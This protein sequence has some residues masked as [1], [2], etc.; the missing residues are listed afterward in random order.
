VASAENSVTSHH[1]HTPDTSRLH[2]FKNFGHTGVEKACEATVAMS[3]VLD[4]IEMCCWEIGEES[5]GMVGQF[6]ANLL[7]NVT[8]CHV[9]R[10]CGLVLKHRKFH[11]VC[12][13]Q[14]GDDSC[15]GVLLFKFYL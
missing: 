1:F 13:D 14:E 4:V 6:S 12:Q 15:T 7:W 8:D 2:G 3:L 5:L 11:F 10:V 9:N